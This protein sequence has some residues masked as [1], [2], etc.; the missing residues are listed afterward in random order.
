MYHTYCPLGN[1]ITQD[2]GK[3]IKTFS[4]IQKRELFYD[5]VGKTKR[6]QR[7]EV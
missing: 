4:K 1:T 5:G 3:V 6:N 2:A 7:R